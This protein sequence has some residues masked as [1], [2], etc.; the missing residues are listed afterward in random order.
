ML[1]KIFNSK[2]KTITS[3]AI[4][5]GVASLV[6]RF[7][8]ILRD[9]ILAGE[10]GA[11]SELDMY[12]TAF[13][14]PDLVFNLLV[15]G[16]LSAGFIPVFTSYMS[17]KDKAWE[18]V[19]VVLNVMF[20]SLILIS[21]L[22]IILAPWLVK[23]IAPGFNGEQLV[24]TTALTRIMFLSPI[25]LG[26]SGVFGSVLQSYKRFFIYSLAPILYNLGIIVGA[27]FFTIKFG[28]F[29]LA[30]GV[31][32]GAFMHML[33]QTIA[34]TFLGYHYKWSFSITHKGLLKILKMM[35]P[36]T[37]GLIITQINF[38]VVTIIGSTLAVGSI[39]IF[40]L[41][42]NI[43][44]FPLGLFAISFAI[45]AFPTL[46]ELANK[47]KQFI[48]AVSLAIRQILFL[49]VPASVLLIILRAQIVR[50]VLGSG[51]FDWEDT[52]LTL[53]T[54]SLFAFS[55]FA[56][57]LIL[58]LARAFYA[59]H[60][61]KTP[62]YTGLVSAFANII[63]AVMLVDQFGVSG[64]ALAFSLSTILNFVLLSLILHY[65]LG[66]LD[67]QRITISTIK[68]TTATFMLAIV[69][70]AAK[71]PLEQIS[72]TQT[73]MGVTAQ[74]LTAII[75]GLATY[76]VVCYFLKSEELNIFISALK[77]KISR[78][79]VIAE[80]IEETEKLT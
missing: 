52:I 39:A 69:A 43:Q 14:F 76:F 33:V 18:L 51:R 79:P 34:I 64:L 11:G 4:I 8:G 29:G 37:L 40:N 44:S 65:R 67:G 31:V 13:R 77:R 19:N 38:L 61:S 23:L 15:L 55:L 70:Q 66:S 48:E 20:F 6:S 16:A 74:A 72:G 60:D 17:N 7:L 42:N 5:L 10:F 12:Y 41:A 53:E 1:K 27:L 35:V 57:G 9:R 24:T 75:A 68:I 50:I 3:A 2:S 59:Q 30:W 32:F 36:R 62:F 47:K 80:E 49:I 78:R 22:A 54:L 56:Q 46:S 71:Y 63:L 25:L 58:I 45:A 28:I 73:F 26:I 21:T